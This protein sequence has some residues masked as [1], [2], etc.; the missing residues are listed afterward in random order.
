MIDDNDKSQPMVVAKLLGTMS[1]CFYLL[2]RVLSFSLIIF[3]ISRVSPRNAC[4]AYIRLTLVLFIY[5]VN[6]SFVTT[7]NC[8]L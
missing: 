6:L 4:H 5:V 8:R 3:Y 7:L 2:L 1:V